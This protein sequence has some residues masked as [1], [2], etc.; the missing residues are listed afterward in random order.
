MK[1]YLAEIIIGGLCVAFFSGFLI[2]SLQI[3]KEYEN[4]LAKLETKFDLC[5]DCSQRNNTIGNYQYRTYKGVDVADNVIV[6]TK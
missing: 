2:W 4:R 6:L 3:L 5:V 1:K